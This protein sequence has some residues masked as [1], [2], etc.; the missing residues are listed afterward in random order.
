M[1]ENGFTLPE[2]VVDDHGQNAG[3]CE[4]EHDAELVPQRD[5]RRVRRVRV[6][7][8]VVAHGVCSSVF[9]LYRYVGE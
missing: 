4:A 9:T 7:D 8:V 5:Y 6:G 2:Y 3:G 1:K